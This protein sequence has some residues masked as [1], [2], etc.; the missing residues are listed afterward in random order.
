VDSEHNLTIDIDDG[1]GKWRD[2]MATADKVCALATWHSHVK[3]RRIR[4]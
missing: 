3:S 4:H 1:R 2:L